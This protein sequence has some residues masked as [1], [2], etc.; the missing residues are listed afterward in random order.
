MTTSIATTLRNYP[1][2]RANLRRPPW[3]YC[4]LMQ[5]TR[6]GLFALLGLTAVLYV[7]G[8]SA[9]G[10]ATAF[11]SAAVQA[12]THRWKATFFAASD[13]AG[14]ITVDKSPLFL[15]PMELAARL[16]AV[17]PWTILVPN[18]IEGVL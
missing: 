7:W 9:S 3:F 10:Y 11:Y 13:A 6:L 16:F 18:A 12:G 17:T 15:W 2:G 4:L 14:S 8:L 5:R 1:W